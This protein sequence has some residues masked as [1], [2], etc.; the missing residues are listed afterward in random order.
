MLNDAAVIAIAVILVLLLVICEKK[1]SVRDL[2]CPGI[3]LG[4]NMR[5]GMI[6]CLNPDLEDRMRSFRPN[7]VRKLS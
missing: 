2:W 3:F 5:K 4:R 1:T 6:E 7:S